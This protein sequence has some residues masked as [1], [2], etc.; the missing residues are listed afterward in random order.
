MFLLHTTPITIRYNGAYFVFEFSYSPFKKKRFFIGIEPFIEVTRF[1][2]K[3]MVNIPELNIVN[4]YSTHYTY[5]D[6]GTSQ[7][8]GWQFNKFSL[9]ANLFLSYKGFLDSDP[10]RFGDLDAFMLPG[11]TFSWKIK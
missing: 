7:F 10:F 4:S 5:F 9:S 6:Y 2:S 3:T 1:H 8:I 11:F